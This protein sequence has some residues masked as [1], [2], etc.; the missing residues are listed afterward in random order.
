MN[1]ND[2]L[3]NKAFCAPISSEDAK[4]HPDLGDGRKS[5]KNNDYYVFNRNGQWY[6]V[7]ERD[8]NG[9]WTHTITWERF[10]LLQSIFNDELKPISEL[11]S[12]SEV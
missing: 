6:F 1:A 4:C 10:L 5:Y 9:N 3:L 2:I 11:P 12:E 7:P 8:E